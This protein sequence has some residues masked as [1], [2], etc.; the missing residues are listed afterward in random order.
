MAPTA[1]PPAKATKEVVIYNNLARPSTSNDWHCDVRYLPRTTPPSYALFLYCVPVQ[2][3]FSERLERLEMSTPGALA[4]LIVHGIVG[5]FS[6]SSLRNAPYTLKCND[7]TLAQEISR[8][9]HMSKV[10]PDR[11]NVGVT[12]KSERTTTIKAQAAKHFDQKGGP[13]G[14]Q[15]PD[16]L[17]VC[18]ACLTAKTRTEMMKCGWCKTVCYCDRDCQGSMWI[19]KHRA[20]CSELAREEG[21]TAFRVQSS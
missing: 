7:V 19:S 8:V 1:P 11:C 9:F 13:G 18:E 3:V 6:R 16:E 10:S 4:K 17:V 2:G 20:I 15:A 14:G 12:A 5:H 21:N